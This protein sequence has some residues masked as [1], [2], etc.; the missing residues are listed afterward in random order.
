MVVEERG[1]SYTGC[2]VS[3]GRFPVRLR[4]SVLA[5]EALHGISASD[6]KSVWFS[7]E[8]TE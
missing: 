3:Q 8:I 6:H 5:L 1:A 7:G 4:D 2:N